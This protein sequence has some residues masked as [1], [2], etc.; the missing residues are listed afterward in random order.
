MIKSAAES[1]GLL[2]IAR[3]GLGGLADRLHLRR[4]RNGPGWQPM[5][6][7][8]CECV[9]CRLRRSATRR[10]ARSTSTGRSRTIRAWSSFGPICLSSALEG[11]EIP[12]AFPAILRELEGVEARF[13]YAV[14][15]STD[16]HLPQPGLYLDHM[17]EV[18][19]LLP[20]LKWRH[21]D[22]L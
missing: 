17:P 12:P 5:R 13:L 15:V 20:Y 10:S 21:L 2:S 11:N 7:P 1:A 18:Q 16:R 4:E 9:E 6:W 8:D 3:D 22:N 14:L 19:P